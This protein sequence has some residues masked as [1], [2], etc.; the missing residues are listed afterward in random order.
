MQAEVGSDDE[1]PGKQPPS[2]SQ[3]VMIEVRRRDGVEQ[4]AGLRQSK[5]RGSSVIVKTVNVALG[6]RLPSAIRAERLDDLFD[7]FDGE[8]VEWRRHGDECPCCVSSERR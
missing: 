2:G 1:G 6:R 8:P 4:L 7:E 3:R 5:Q